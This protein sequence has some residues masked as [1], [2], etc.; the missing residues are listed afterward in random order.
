MTD[1]SG[2]SFKIG[3]IVLQNLCSKTQFLVQLAPP[4]PIY[5]NGLMSSIL[6]NFIISTVIQKT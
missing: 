3:K 1:S 6:S 4:S 5:T 2:A